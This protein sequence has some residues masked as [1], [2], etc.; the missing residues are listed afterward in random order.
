MSNAESRRFQILSLGA[1]GRKGVFASSFLTELERMTGKRVVD[2]FDLIAGTSTGGI[3]ALGLGLG[4]SA[5]DLRDFYV[6][7][8]PVIFPSVGLGVGLRRRL[9]WLVWGKHDPEPLKAALRTAFGEKRL[10]D[11]QC[12]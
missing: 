1:G 12:R 3:I 5:T 4:L 2:H 6:S 9:Q 11:S 10:S 8:G 7:N